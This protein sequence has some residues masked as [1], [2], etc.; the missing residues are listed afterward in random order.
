LNIYYWVVD[1]LVPELFPLYSCPIGNNHKQTPSKAEINTRQID[2]DRKDRKIL[3]FSTRQNIT[4]HSGHAP[5]TRAYLCTQEYINTN[6]T[7]RYTHTHSMGFFDASFD[8]PSNWY[9]QD[10]VLCQLLFSFHFN[11]SSISSALHLLW[12]LLFKPSIVW[13]VLPW[14]V[15]LWY[16]YR[17]VSHRIQRIEAS[18]IFWSYSWGKMLLDLLDHS[19]DHTQENKNQW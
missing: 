18:N 8:I 16:R 1:N 4:I 5:Y 6:N 2:Q 9:T 10:I 19:K 15:R 14:L 13:L 17:G 12:I 7:Q 3:T 11:L